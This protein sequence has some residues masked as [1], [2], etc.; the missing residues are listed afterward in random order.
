MNKIN[1]LS[2]QSKVYKILNGNN[3]NKKIN[4]IK[5]LHNNI[6]THELLILPKPTFESS[7]TLSKPFESSKLHKLS[8]TISN[9]AQQID[10]NGYA[11]KYIDNNNE[12]S[13]RYKIIMSYP[14]LVP[15]LKQQNP[16]TTMKDIMMQINK[17]YN[18]RKSNGLFYPMDYLTINKLSNLDP[19]KLSSITNTNYFNNN[20]PYNF[21]LKQGAKPSEA[22]R[23]LLEGPTIC[24]CGNVIQIV[25]YQHILNI[26]GVDKFDA[27]FSKSLSVL[28]ITQ[29]LFNVVNPEKITGQFDTHIKLNGNPLFFLFD[30]VDVSDISNLSDGDIVHISG[31][32]NSKYKHPRNCDI[33]WNVICVKESS[34]SDLKFIGFGPNEF[35]TPL[36]HNQIKRILIDKHNEKPHQKSRQN[37]LNNSKDEIEKSLVELLENDTVTY[38]Y[39]TKGIVAGI[40][41]NKD[42]LINF[43]NDS[44]NSNVWHRNID[45]LN[46]PI[47]LPEVSNNKIVELSQ[48]PTNLKNI[49]FDN[50]ISD[51]IHSQNLKNCY[52]QF[53]NAV[54][55]SRVNNWSEPIG[56]IISGNAGIG[57]TFLSIAT[58]SYL[59]NYG[60]KVLFID[61]KF[62]GTKYNVMEGRMY[63]Y[64]QHFENVDLIIFDDVNSNGVSALM[65]KMIF[66]YVFDN[67]KSFIITSNCNN[68]KYLTNLPK[69][70]E[71]NDVISNNIMLYDDRNIDSKRFPWCDSVIGKSIDD[72]LDFDSPIPKIITLPPTYTKSSI[73]I[74]YMEKTSNS[75][76][77]KVVGNPLN[78][79]G[80]IAD[81]FDDIDKYDIFIVDATM[82]YCGY[83]LCNLIEKVFKIGGKIIAISNTNAEFHYVVMK[84]INCITNKHNKIKM[85]DRFRVMFPLDVEQV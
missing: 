16:D 42:K 63:D 40:R 69:Y 82:P 41:F 76:K 26:I 53:C 67:N 12:G 21:T 29:E 20:L 14:K 48:I 27:I 8:G 1:K 62:I 32:P 3:P 55:N 4:T 81:Y 34:D 71:L 77:I 35:Q 80:T 84:E 57:K 31:I 45:Y 51:N 50:Y 70:F 10:T 65:L 61:E 52:V 18:L 5:K 28:Q 75:A 47:S 6:N 72:M 13:L 37:Y 68:Y 85:L 30:V 74:E 56:M 23:A 25:V 79:E 73:K 78:T 24:D 39:E 58:G 11:S 15:S 54:I 64:S 33:G 19:S 7:H 17:S 36:T 44:L 60:I 9:H 22:L 38:E 66:K 46:L 49:T 43:V 83:Q 2:R 59:N